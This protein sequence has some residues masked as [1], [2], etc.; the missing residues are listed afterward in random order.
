MNS[1]NKDRDLIRKGKFY[2]FLSNKFRLSNGKNPVLEAFL[3]H[4]KDTL[5]ATILLN[6]DYDLSY[7]FTESDM[8]FLKRY[9]KLEDL[10]KDS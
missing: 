2:E 8:E 3:E 1:W 5:S 6:E 9:F 10:D 7:L 4:A